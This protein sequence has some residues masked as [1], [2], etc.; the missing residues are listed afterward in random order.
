MNFPNF[1]G[2]GGIDKD[3][4]DELECARIGVRQLVARQS[5]EVDTGIIGMLEGWRFTRAWRYWVANGPGIPTADAED[6]HDARGTEVRV[7]GHCGCP[8][9]TAWCGD[10][11]VTMY[12]VDTQAGLCALADTIRRASLAIAEAGEGEA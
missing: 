7:A 2:R 1:A 11:P 4:A 9:P 12:H 8:S 5:G 10:K 3:V 6:L